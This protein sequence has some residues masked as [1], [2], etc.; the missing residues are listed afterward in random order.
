VQQLLEVLRNEIGERLKSAQNFLDAGQV[1]RVGN[2]EATRS[3][4]TDANR[5]GECS[6]GTQPLIASFS[7]L[8]RAGCLVISVFNVCG[9]FD[10]ETI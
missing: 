10:S 7:C 9:A 1:V 6:L 5:G 8:K 4:I 3:R 2:S